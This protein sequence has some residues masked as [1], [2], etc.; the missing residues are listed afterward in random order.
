MDE[1]GWEDVTPVAHYQLYYEEKGDTTVSP[2]LSAMIQRLLICVF[3]LLLFGMAQAEVKRTTVPI[4][5]SPAFGPGDAP[6]T[7]IE[8]IDF[9]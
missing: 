5:D 2:F 4:G 3:V 9:Q 1:S 8:F 7:I 6:V